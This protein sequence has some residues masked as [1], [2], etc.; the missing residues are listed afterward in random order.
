[1]NLTTLTLTVRQEDK[2]SIPTHSGSMLRGAFG[3]ALRRLSC[4]TELPDCQLC[5]LKT[6]CPYTQLFENTDDNSTN[7][8]V[9]RL[10]KAQTVLPHHTWQFG[11][12]LIGTA[13]E[14]HK[15]IIKAWQEALL[16][17]VGGGRHRAVAK[18][19]K[20]S[21]MGQTIFEQDKFITPQAYTLKAPPMPTID[22]PTHLGLHFITPFRL[23]YQGKIAHQSHQFE[24]KQLLINLYNRITRCQTNHDNASDWQI[25]Y[26]D[27]HEFLAD[28][29]QLTFDSKVSPVNVNRHSSRQGRKITLFG[30]TGDVFITGDDKILSRL[31][32][33]LWLGQYIHVGKS[34]TLGLG[35]YQ[36]QI[37]HH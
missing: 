7:P 18:L 4:L 19:I 1:M 27:F 31:L 6:V 28:V 15:L 22:K 29:E 21:N 13:T 3:M 36:L 5:P 37:R 16:M 9:L 30:M 20:V 10:P 14:H 25:G 33:L 17:G 35:Q 8:Y 34:T 23:Q 12:T 32:P 26:Q 24:P 11:M 2:L